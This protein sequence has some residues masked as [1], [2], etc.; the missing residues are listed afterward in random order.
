MIIQTICIYIM[1]GCLWSFW[2]ESYTIK[3]LKPPYNQPWSNRERVFHTFIWV[4]SFG[5]FVYTLF[6]DFFG[7]YFD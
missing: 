2:L 6:K 1:I 5:L 3:E 4:W 7:N